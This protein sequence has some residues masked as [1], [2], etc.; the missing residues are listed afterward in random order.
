[1]SGR[2]PKASS[3][4]KSL[5]GRH[6]S[7]SRAPG[8]RT[9][10]RSRPLSRVFAAALLVLVSLGAL[11]AFTWPFL[12]AAVPGDA[13]GAIPALALAMIV[14]LAAAVIVALSDGASGAMFVAMLGTLTA[15]GMVMRFLG[16]GFGGFE[17]ALILLILAGRAFGPRFGFLLGATVMLGSSL[18]WG[19][20]GPWLPFQVFAA[21]WVGAVAGLIPGGR[22]L[23]GSRTRWPELALLATYGVLASYAFGLL[24]NVWFWPFA[25]GSDTSISYVSDAWAGANL[26]R[27]LSYSF[28][29]ST[30]TWDTVRA[31]TTAAGILLIGRPVLAALRR[32]ALARRQ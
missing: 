9:F 28:I 22:R 23:A 17:T 16:T 12:A 31:I 3:A 18:L 26:V 15:V 4:E 8:A 1:M 6:T 30:L 7:G 27:F 25:V 32:S 14:V 2:V 19:G 29:T 20:V 11:A 24:M 5:R 21:G 13:R 10:R